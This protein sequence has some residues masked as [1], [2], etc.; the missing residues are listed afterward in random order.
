MLSPEYLAGLLDGEGHISIDSASGK[1]RVNIAN[2]YVFGGFGIYI[3]SV[4]P[5]FPKKPPRGQFQRPALLMA[6]FASEEQIRLLMEKADKRLQVRRVFKSVWKRPKSRDKIDG[7]I[8]NCAKNLLNLTKGKTLRIHCKDDAELQKRFYD[9]FLEENEKEKT[10]CK[11]DYDEYDIL[12]W[13]KEYASE[14]KHWFITSAEGL[15]P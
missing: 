3:E 7:F 13:V 1:A 11:F 14:E 4:T 6:K 15:P 12:F 2:T 5:I 8:R 9:I 10:N